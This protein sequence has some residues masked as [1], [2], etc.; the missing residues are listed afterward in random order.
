MVYVLSVGL[1]AAFI[2]NDEYKWAAFIAMLSIVHLLDS[3]N[4]E[5]R[6]RR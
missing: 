3:I 5:L 6:G 4:Q 1:F 2:H